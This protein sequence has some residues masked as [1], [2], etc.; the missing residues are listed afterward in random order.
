M[1]VLPAE[2]ARQAGVTRQSI[3][4]KIKKGTL[5][6]NS[7]GKL[8][9]ENPVNAGYLAMKR[10]QLEETQAANAALIAQSGGVDVKSTGGQT[11]TI[12]KPFVEQTA[13]RAIGVPAELLTLTLKELVMRYSGVL[14]LEKHAKILKILVES[15]EKEQRIK[16]RRLTLVDKDFV[17]SRLFQ[18]MDN[19]MVQ[20]LEYPESAADNLVAQVLADTETARKTVANAMKTD[21]S[22]ILAGAKEHIIQELNGLKHKYHDD[23][24]ADTIADLKQEIKNELEAEQDDE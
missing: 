17:V 9:T 7:A 15:A 5:I 16:E 12:Q 8:D 21:L 19:L 4:A 1:E 2:F 14:P 3:C 22:K 24:T 23:S 20:L 6:Q 10:R 18:F 11:H 13:A